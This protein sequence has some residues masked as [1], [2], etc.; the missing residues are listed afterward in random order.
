MVD[1]SDDIPLSSVVENFKE[2]LLSPAVV[3]VK[4]PLDEVTLGIIVKSGFEL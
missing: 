2:L 3:L 4:P 1:F